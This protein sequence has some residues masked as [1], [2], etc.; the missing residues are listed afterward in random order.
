MSLLTRHT[1]S[2][3]SCAGHTE[4]W[5]TRRLAP[6][7]SLFLRAWRLISDTYGGN[8]QSTCSPSSFVQT[9]N[10]SKDALAVLNSEGLIPYV[11]IVP[12][13]T[14]A[15]KGQWK[16]WPVSVWQA[17]RIWSVA[18]IKGDAPSLRFP[19]ILSRFFLSVHFVITM[20]LVYTTWWPLVL[21]QLVSGEIFPILTLTPGFCSRQPSNTL[22]LDL[23]DQVILVSSAVARF[24]TALDVSAI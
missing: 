2:Q 13:M 9:K 17:H 18:R 6:P 16:S 10:G 1:P 15:A 14:W 24:A 21:G 19:E 7:V 3:K 4:S 12:S 22:P 11:D 8:L 23:I 5:H 20:P